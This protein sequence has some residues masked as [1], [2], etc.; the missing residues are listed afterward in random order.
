MHGLPVTCWTYDRLQGA[1]AFPANSLRPGK[2]R[3]AIGLSVEALL[4]QVLMGKLNRFSGATRCPVT[5]PARQDKTQPAERWRAVAI[6]KTPSSP[7]LLSQIQ[8]VKNVRLFSLNHVLPFH[9]QSVQ[10]RFTL[11]GKN[12]YDTNNNESVC[13]WLR[14]LPLSDLLARGSGRFPNP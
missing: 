11:M 5:F 14:R 7:L 9:R 4:L 13:L 8:T 1:P 12:R 2:T 10:L 6:P 3:S